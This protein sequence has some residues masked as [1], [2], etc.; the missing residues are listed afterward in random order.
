M[1]EYL[2]NNLKLKKRRKHLRNKA[3][4]AEIILW[5]YLMGKQ[6]QGYK[7]R[8]QHSIGDYIVDFYCPELRLAIE[9]DG[10]QHSQKK[11]IEYDQQRTKYLNSQNIKVLRYWNND[12][13]N[14][15]NGVID[16]ILS[17]IPPR[18]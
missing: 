6:L 4:D 9:L 16:E 2:Y 18:L 14:N 13:Y 12:I 8:R 7:F 17:L 10:E 3:Q 15:L 5:S 11:S 1:L